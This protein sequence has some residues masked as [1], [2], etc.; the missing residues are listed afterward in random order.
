MHQCRQDIN[1]N[2]LSWWHFYQEPRPL[3][4][5][6]L[7]RVVATTTKTNIA[8]TE[9]SRLGSQSSGWSRQRESDDYQVQ[10]AINE[11]SKLVVSQILNLQSD[12]QDP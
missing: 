11:L 6:D 9:Y 5:S 12:S 3:S 8:A 10:A 4:Q 7:E 1:I 2:S